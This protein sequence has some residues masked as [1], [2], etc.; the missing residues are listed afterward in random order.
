MKDVVSKNLK[1]NGRKVFTKKRGNS[2]I[3]KNYNPFEVNCKIYKRRSGL[4][5]NNVV[6]NKAKK[7][8]CNEYNVKEKVV[9][10]LFEKCKEANYNTKESKKLIAEFLEINN[11]SKTCPLF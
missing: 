7:E 2:K 8:L 10:I 9:E 11:L 1:E 5:M 3:N 6:L 4:Y